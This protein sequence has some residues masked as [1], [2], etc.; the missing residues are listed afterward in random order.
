VQKKEMQ[1]PV[2]KRNSGFATDVTLFDLLSLNWAGV[3]AYIGRFEQRP[4][5]P[6]CQAF[7]S[8]GDLFAVIDQDT[9]SVLVPYGRGKEIIQNL[10]TTSHLPATAE[11]LKEAQQYSVN[12]YKN[13]V[14]SLDNGIY[15]IGDTGVL[16]LADL[17][18]SSEYGITL[19]T[20]N[21]PVI[22]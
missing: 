10:A 21:E 1:Y 17:Y 2:S 14:Q 22:F 20:D 7:A 3:K 4:G 19:I 8:S 11:L 6:F 5:Y 9:E 16:A 15:S 12:L 18:Y 13:E